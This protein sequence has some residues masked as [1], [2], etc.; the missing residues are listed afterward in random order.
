[1]YKVTPIKTFSLPFSSVIIFSFSKL[2]LANCLIHHRT[3]AQ[4]IMAA[5]PAALAVV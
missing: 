5:P 4:L 3:T 1:M 2:S